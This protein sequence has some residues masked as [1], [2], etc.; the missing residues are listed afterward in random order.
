MFIGE[1]QHN[2]DAKGRIIVPAK[3][4][5]ELGAS[6][7]IAKGF[8]GCLD[9]WTLPAWEH[10]LQQIRQIPQT[11]S[12]AR[13]FVRGLTAKATHV[14]VDKQ[15]RVLVPSN[16]MS[17]AGLEKNCVIIGASDHVELWDQERWDQYYSDASES[18]EEV[19]EHLTEYLI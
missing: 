10:R 8:D 16:L 2:L 11:T 9:F 1:F 7:V 13:K 12:E 6:F 3:L 18:F 17:E 14:E 15:G 19:A 5:D 4:R